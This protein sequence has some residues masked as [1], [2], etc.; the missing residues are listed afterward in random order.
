VKYA[1]LQAHER[2]F[3]VVAMCRVLDV[4]RSGYYAWK[5][6]GETPREAENR[7]LDEAIQHLFDCHKG[8]YG[9]P[10]LTLELRAEGWTVS[11]RVAK[12]MRA[13]GLRAKAARKYKATTQSKHALP[14]APNRLEQ[15][16]TARR[17]IGPGWRI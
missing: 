7:R 9:A 2:Q 16:F 1:F 3:S 15:N 11:R 17:Q 4:P 6:R 14:V 12:R 10:R 13:L 8:W 5:L